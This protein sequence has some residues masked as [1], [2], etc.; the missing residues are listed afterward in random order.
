MS[1]SN[2]SPSDEARSESMGGQS[3]VPLQ[4]GPY[5]ILD[6]LGAG[7]MGEVY[8][9]EQTEPVKRRVALKL[10]KLGMDSHEVVA[11]FRQE[12]QALALMSHDSIA[13]VFDVGT[14]E[15]GQP[16]FVMELVKGVP[17][18]QY[19]D[20]HRL[21]I[22][23]RIGLMQQ[24][25]SAVTHAHQKGVV[26]RDLK[27]GNVLVS[28]EGGVP[29]AK[30][31]D[32]G[33][34]KAMGP[35]LTEASLFTEPGRVMG[36][37]EYMAPEQAD[38]TNAD[39]D[40]RADVYSLG[41]IL[42]KLL[43]GEL[44]F[45][46]ERLRR[47]GLLGIQRVL[48]E[49]EPPRPSQKLSSLGPAT[50]T[51]SAARRTSTAALQRALR[52]DLDWVVLKAL[53]KDRNRRYDS[54]AALAAD[55]Q[56]FL[57]H[58][59]LL[60]GPPSAWYRTQ[61]LLRRYRGQAI[62]LGAVTVAL[63]AGFG[64]A[65]WQADV[66]AHERD[67]AVQAGRRE[68]KQRAEADQQRARADERAAAAERAEKAERERADQLKQVSDFQAQMLSQMDTTKAGL[69]LMKDVR[70][71]FAAALEKAGVP[72]VERKTQ[73]ESLRSLLVRVNAT[74]TAA[75]MID[76]TIL[77]PAV[78]AIDKQF[79]DQPLVDAQ[80]RQALADLYR[81]IGLYDAAYPLQESALATRRRV[82]GE[83]H[84]ETYSSLNNMSMLLQDQGKLAEAEPLRRKTLEIGRRILGEEH[85][86][87][88]AF[89]N[90]MGS[91]LEAQGKL[92]QAEQYYKEALEKRRRLLGEEHP[93]TLTSQNNLGVVLQSQ[94]KL[95]QAEPLFV[96]ALD[97]RRR[98]LGEEHPDTLGSLHNLATLLTNQGKPNQAE[99]LFRQVQEKLRLARGEEH[100]ETLVS[101]SNLASV[102]RHQGKFDQAE[103]LF[104]ETLEGRRRVLG[105]EHPDTL[106]AL[107]NLGGAYLE[108]GKLSQAEPLFREALERTR[109]LLGEDHPDTLTALSNLGSVL[110][111]QGKL[112]QAEPH[113]RDALERI[114][115]VLGED[116][117]RTIAS[118][119]NLGALLQ[120]EGKLQEAEPLFRDA[121]EKR[122]RSLGR[123]HP[124][125][126]RSLNKLGSLLQAQGMFE[127]AESLIREALENRRLLLGEEHLETLNS[128][129]NLGLLLQAQGKLD[130][131]ELLLREALEK[132]RHALGN[133]HP[134]TLSSINNLGLLLQAQGKL[135]QA[136]PLYREALEKR[137]RLLGEEHPTTL[138]SI[139]NLGFLLYAQNKLDQ[140]ETLFGEA[141]EKRR[142][143]LGEQHPDTL[144]SIN[145]LG[146]L[147]LRQGKYQKSLELLDAAAPAARKV[148]GGGNAKLLS[149]FLTILGRAQMGL[150]FERERFARA[151]AN[152][153]EAHRQYVKTL[154]AANSET[155]ACVRWLVDLYTAW[156]AAEPGKG[157]DAKAAEWKTKLDAAQAKPS[158]APG[159]SN[160]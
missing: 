27:P 15:R 38:P 98:L 65:L 102:L 61:K 136:E 160:K 101:L 18:D 155:L 86:N 69:D 64:T 115:R 57:E 6:R 148:F 150:G 116:H 118:L 54:P 77:K 100:P 130:Q 131:A 141:L 12:Q 140:A 90:N 156:H 157:Y 22:E 66:A 79:K 17:L 145:N 159:A 82:L 127:E 10:I 21:G 84:P 123:Q 120:A 147:L 117:P 11:R 83:E 78:A 55:L 81:T 51:V 153:I 111:D 31:I 29:H 99:P 47:G 107:N 1:D 63:L 135:D 110:M 94:G 70:E 133:E 42:Y 36:T 126:L 59:P 41:V 25:C 149:G 40:T 9:A 113:Y 67:E 88:L 13:K 24:V 45:S 89:I 137:R 151:E 49:E 87:T 114:R 74:D 142:N 16:Y 105:D 7:G 50:T 125:T 72:E 52:T 139:N 33:L 132:R 144:K 46:S 143:L 32:F 68:S 91:L 138:T 80:L 62:A 2:P 146:G 53:E 129:N 58:E 95:E 43:V 106:N 73:T 19:C 75:A 97:R 152:F 122:Q 134:E 14:T 158:T 23:Q 104:Y 109:H 76:R 154:G 26:H 30:V 96:E 39:I 124:D 128:M 103:S 121:L 112:G 28:D 35:R 3:S 71:R 108:Q 20:T 92:D 4:I 37:P 34:A 8:V 119:G 93:D 85:P 48:R 5:R 56:R 60:A 44:P